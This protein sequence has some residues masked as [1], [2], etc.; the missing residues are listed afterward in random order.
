MAMT[1]N[2]YCPKCGSR[3][4]PIDEEYIRK[5][6]VCSYCVTVKR[7]YEPKKQKKTIIKFLNK[8]V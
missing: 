1:Q 7:M 5:H 3:L 8:V 4:Y 6:G 2:S